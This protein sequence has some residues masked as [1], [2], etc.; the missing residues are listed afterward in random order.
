MATLPQIRKLLLPEIVPDPVITI[1]PAGDRGIC[2]WYRAHSGLEGTYMGVRI[3]GATR[4]HVQKERTRHA[5][6]ACGAQLRVTEEE[7]APQG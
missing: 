1:L 7:Y 4:H 6:C 5:E 3:K 2:D